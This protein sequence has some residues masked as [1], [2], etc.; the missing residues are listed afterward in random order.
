MK[1]G[2]KVLNSAAAATIAVAGLLA[3]PAASAV[4]N[5][6]SVWE[7]CAGIAAA[8]KNDCGTANHACAGQSTINNA[9]DEWVYVPKGTCEKISGG[10]VLG[11]KPAKS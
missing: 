7:K 10:T 5:N 9:P 11:E 2:L 4:P 8:G 6:P 1:T 3:A